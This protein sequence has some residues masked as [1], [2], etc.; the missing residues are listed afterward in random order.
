ME[1][2]QPVSTTCSVTAA[3][4]TQSTIP[5]LG[6]GRSVA[7]PPPEPE[8]VPIAATPVNE[9]QLTVEVG[10]CPTTEHLEK[11]CCIQ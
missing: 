4:E 5:S 6:E 2:K 8:I 1:D 10:D 9:P 11:N 3:Q 7:F